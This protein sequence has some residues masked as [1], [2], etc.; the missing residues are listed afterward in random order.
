MNENFD[1]ICR[2]LENEEVGFQ[3]DTEKHLIGAHV[4][5]KN[6]AV[7]MIVHAPS[8]ESYLGLILVLPVVAPPERR[9]VVGEFLHRANQFIRVGAFELNYDDGEVRFAM[10][11][12]LA[13]DYTLPEETF[14]RWLSFAAI[15][16]DGFV[17]LLMRVAFGN[18]SPASAIE[19]S[20][21]VL[22]DFMRHLGFSED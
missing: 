2:H 13:E 21:A 3:T 11:A 8:D 22:K 7:Q 1:I 10:S 4:G 17:P 19:Q 15:T 20:E 9:A 18:L 6:V 5:L 14:R 12:L 16:V